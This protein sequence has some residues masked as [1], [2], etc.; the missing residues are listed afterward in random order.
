MVWITFTVTYMVMPNAKVKFGSALIAGIVAGTLFQIIQWL[1][2][3]LQ[4]SASRLGALYGSFAAFPLF[5]LWIQMSW[6]IVL[7][8]AEI[9]F[10]NQNVNR[11]EFE[12]DSL[13]ISSF[14]KRRL[15]ILI[16]RNIINNFAKGVPPASAEAISTDLKIPVRIA[17]EILHDLETAGLISVIYSEKTKD[18]YFQPAMDINKITVGFVISKLDRV[19]TDHT[20]AMKDGGYDKVTLML[21]E[22]DSLVHLSEYNKLIKDI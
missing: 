14:H 13:N 17:R 1:Y 10:A 11:Y 3:D 20:I 16:I 2:I 9:S 12:S 8:G 7:M 15:V 5:L 22:F 6:L 18:K 21:E 19:G 4:I